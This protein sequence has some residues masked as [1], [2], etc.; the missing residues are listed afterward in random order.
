[1]YPLAVPILHAVYP[2][3]VPIL[4]AVYPSAGPILP[5]V[6]PLAYF[7]ECVC[8]CAWHSA[9]G[10]FSYEKCLASFHQYAVES[11]IQKSDTTEFFTIIQ[12]FQ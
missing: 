12:R 6:Y 1:M 4:P 7:H 8:L 10:L 11:V 3:A 5:P 9:H 2:L